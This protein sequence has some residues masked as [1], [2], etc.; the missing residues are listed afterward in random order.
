MKGLSRTPDGKLRCTHSSSVSLHL[1]V[2]T[3]GVLLCVTS[4]KLDVRTASSGLFH[5]SRSLPWCALSL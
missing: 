1:P 4:A 3:V 2:W 5:G